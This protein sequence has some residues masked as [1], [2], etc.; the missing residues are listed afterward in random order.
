M[1]E[2]TKQTDRKK[3][4]AEMSASSFDTPNDLYNSIS[5]ASIDQ[6][7]D[8]RKKVGV[9]SAFI[10][11]L[12]SDLE[13]SQD[14]DPSYKPTFGEDVA[15]GLTDFVRSGV[16]V[17]VELWDKNTKDAREQ[18]NKIRQYDPELADQIEATTIG[19]ELT[20]KQLALKGGAALAEGVLSVVPFF[21]AGR[22]AITVAEKAAVSRLGSI[23]V[24][25][26]SN[27]V[28]SKLYMGGVNGALYGGLYGLHKYDGDWK[29]AV[30]GAAMGGVFGGGLMGLGHGIN[31]GA[32][33]AGRTAIKVGNVLKSTGQTFDE[34]VLQKLP[35]K[36]YS[37]VFSVDATMKKYYGEVGKNFS[38][39]FRSASKEATRDLGTVQLSLID[40]GLI[41][42]PTGLGKAFKGIKF[43]GDDVELMGHYNQVLRG[44]GVYSDKIVR[45]QAISVDPRLEF[46]DSLRKTY[47]ARS[48]R[49]GV[50]ES[51]LDLDTYL[52][53][54][55]PIVEAKK[56]TRRAI[57]KATTVGEREAIYAANDPMVKEM[58]EN[59][60]FTEKAFKTLDEAYQNYYDYTDLVS[61]GAHTPLADNKFL[62]KMVANGEAR[63]MEEAKGKLIEDMKFRKKSLTPLAS[64]LDFKRKISLPWY[65]PNPARVMPQYAFDAS[66][67]IEMAKK[68][69]KDDEVIRAMLGKVENDLNRGV[70]AEKAAQTFEDFIR[71]T[72]GQVMRSPGEEK[73]S[74]FLR[75]LQVPK[76]AFAQIINLGQSLN[77]LLASDFGSTMTGLTTAFKTKNIRKAIGDG[78]LLNNFMR[79]ISNYNT[80]G[81]KMAENI[82]KYSGFTYT[83]MFNRAVGSI[84]SDLWTNQNLKGLIKKYGLPELTENERKS[85]TKMLKD[86]SLMDKEA[87]LGGIDVQKEL[88]DEF[89]RLFPEED[90]TAAA[91]N[92]GAA[93]KRLSTL[94]KSI[95]DKTGKLQKTKE[96]L[97]KELRAEAAPFTKSDTEDLRTI[98]D[99]LREEISASKGV[100]IGKEQVVGKQF[101]P[102]EVK[103]A[104]DGATQLERADL[105]S[106]IA[107]LEVKFDESRALGSMPRDVVTVRGKA[108]ASD[109]SLGNF[110]A[111][112]NEEIKG[113]DSAMA[114]L[115]NELTDKQRILESAINSYDISAKRAIEKV[116]GGTKYDEF[117][118]SRKKNIGTD[119]ERIKKEQ[120]RE[121]RALE[122]LGVPTDDVIA[123]GFI[124]PEERALASQKFVENTQFLGQPID[125]PYFSS[126]PAGKVMFQFKTFAYQQARFVTRE[127]KKDFAAKDF[128]RGF[129]NL[130][131]LGTV[132][133]MTGEV[134]AD[135][136]SLITQEKRPTKFL[137][138]YIADLFAA[139]TYGMFYDFYKSAESG[140][141]AEFIAGA[142]AGDVIRYLENIAKVPGRIKAGKP[143]QSLKAFTK[144]L[145]RQTGVGRPAVNVLFPSARREGKTS[146]ESLIEWSADK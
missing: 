131:I 137:D 109:E 74:S 144:D 29:E 11:G 85:V 58:V 128:S 107:R 141:T 23:G 18:L 79:E 20:D 7:L 78:V 108:G 10:K 142:T 95:A 86:K 83:E 66:M 76:L 143:E 135:V 118:A 91:G 116:P 146:L 31:I 49:E 56:S 133:P 123:R 98:I 6:N 2:I 32:K 19:T 125:L 112:I 51:L 40:N 68:F 75:A 93:R 120:P 25:I 39:M 126:T 45:T 64:S 15:S 114:G 84:A 82:L 129:R 16:K 122:E 8:Y 104:L 55:T 12:P 103:A 41:K 65:D 14:F 67:R 71:A 136:R 57:A 110:V 52:P 5:P 80:G 46:L 44:K 54:H 36:W 100:F 115:Q 88:F 106:I 24:K 62:R 99:S 47:G 140:R 138:R 96:L 111:G 60:V 130:L 53:K 34:K 70:S 124:L 42:P 63:T 113:L 121:F 4:W 22:T 17:G 117:I 77:T 87:L 69:G 21:K 27:P 26:A 105:E 139:G 33:L 13:S 9:G 50:V 90:F 92:L 127:L 35:A 30:K 38:D 37:S 72:T 59:S 94:E 132:F 3:A 89:R 119:L 102:Q 28:L 48:Q 1:A 145:L 73:A 61:G 101:S 97:Q 43:V 81:S 134:L